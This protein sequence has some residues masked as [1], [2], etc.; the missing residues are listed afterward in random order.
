MDVTTRNG[1]TA[2]AR[3]FLEP[4]GPLQRQYEAFRAY[5]VEARAAAAAVQGMT[6]N[7]CTCHRGVF[8]VT[9]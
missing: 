4:E 2:E 8:Q 9:S 6:S 7:A 3:F 5:F 1:L